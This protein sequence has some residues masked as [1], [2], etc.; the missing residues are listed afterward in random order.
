[1]HFWAWTLEIHSL[2]LSRLVLVLSFISVVYFCFSCQCD[3]HW[4]VQQCIV[5][6]Q[7]ENATIDV[8]NFPTCW[9]DMCFVLT[10]F[11]GWHV[12][13]THMLRRIQLNFN[14]VPLKQWSRSFTKPH[15]ICDLV[16]LVTHYFILLIAQIISAFIISKRLHFAQTNCVDTFFSLLFV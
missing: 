16:C 1:M 11:I 10:V 4:C 12:C 14:C 15:S 2:L 5:R 9:C 8:Y 6:V 13:F 7:F 3:W